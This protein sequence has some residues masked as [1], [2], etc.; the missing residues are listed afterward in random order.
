VLEFAVMLLAIVAPL[1]ARGQP[2][3]PLVDARQLPVGT[4]DL[5]QSWRVHEDEAQSEGGEL[6]GFD[7]TRELSSLPASEIVSRAQQF[8]QEDD[9]TVL[10][11]TFAPLPEGMHT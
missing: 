8:G 11:L 9:I 2:G 7:R 1:V 6:F 10:T 3:A 5:T 4:L